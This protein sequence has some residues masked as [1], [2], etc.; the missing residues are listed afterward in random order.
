M[1]AAGIAYAFG[2]Y[3]FTLDTSDPCNFRKYK[4]VVIVQFFTIWYTRAWLWFTSAYQ[5]LR[6]FYNDDANENHMIFFWGGSVVV[7]TMSLF[8]LVMLI[9]C[10]TAAIKWLP[11]K[12]PASKEEKAAL[13]NTVAQSLAAQRGQTF[14]NGEQ[15]ANDIGLP[16]PKR[17]SQRASLKMFQEELTKD[18]KRKSGEIES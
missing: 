5:L 8:N 9:D 7:F 4:A 3:K 11:R 14:G 6:H 10:T 13:A 12:A 18:E 1:G 16:M 2:S 15:V 17:V